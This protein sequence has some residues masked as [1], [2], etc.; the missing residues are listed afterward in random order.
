MLPWFYYNNSDTSVSNHTCIFKKVQTFQRI[1]QSGASIWKAASW[2]D[3]WCQNI[4]QDQASGEN[5][6]IPYKKYEE[7]NRG[8]R[9]IADPKPRAKRKLSMANGPSPKRF[10]PDQ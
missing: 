7:R 3:G 2:N 6:S 1:L 8:D 4:L 10:Q 5:A 9:S